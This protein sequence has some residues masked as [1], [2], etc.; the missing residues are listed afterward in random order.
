MDL[1]LAIA[2]GFHNAP[3]LY[4]DTTVRT[5]IRI[6]GFHSG[7][8]AAGEEF[9]LGIYDGVTGLVLQPY[10]GAKENGTLGFV[11]GLGKG[12]GGFV[13][14]DLAAIFG[15][16]GYTLKGVHKE[17]VKNKQPT[18]FIRRSRIIQGG[19]DLKALD[20]E[21]RHE[22]EQKVDAAWKVLEE[23]KNEEY[24]VRSTGIVGRIKAKRVKRNLD[25]QGAFESVDR[26]KKV[27]E[28]RKMSR[29][30]G[31]DRRLNAENKEKVPEQFIQGKKGPKK[32]KLVKFK[33]D[34]K[35]ADEKEK[36]NGVKGGVK[37]QPQVDENVDEVEPNGVLRNGSVNTTAPE[38]RPN[39]VP[40]TNEV[41]VQSPSPIDAS[42]MGLQSNEHN[43][44]PSRT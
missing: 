11:Q 14:K 3:R 20:E 38:K 2:Q 36:L 31:E 28:D 44:Q 8:R 17:L 9:T 12:I 25:A 6:T 22:D 21:Q 15:P 19:K 37:G 5:P 23:I 1:S 39:G 13:L 43:K 40:T 30:I 27:V 42:P 16:V 10:H 24:M 35:G 7:L 33:E 26:A 32:N 34:R 4:G 41:I 18:A 29:F